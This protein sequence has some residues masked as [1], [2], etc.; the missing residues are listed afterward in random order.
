MVAKFNPGCPCCG[1]KIYKRIGFEETPWF[2]LRQWIADTVVT[3]VAQIPTLLPLCEGFAAG[4]NSQCGENKLQIHALGDTFRPWIE[5]GGRLLINGE[6]SRF[7]DQYPTLPILDC[8][9]PVERTRIN[10]FMAA[11]GSTMRLQVGLCNCCCDDPR[12]VSNVNTSL[13]ITQEI[14]EIYTACTAPITGGTWIA[15]TIG[16][17]DNEDCFGDHPTCATPYTWLAIEKIGEG[18]VMM[19]GDGNLT[20]GCSHDNCELVR[21]FFMREE[22]L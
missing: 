22:L 9:P 1:C 4:F 12:W 6:F 3:G 5:A 19:S 8:C 18:Y 11:I 14:D 15:K 10:N 7:P 21:R 13:A 20:E 16:T 2:Q 17:T